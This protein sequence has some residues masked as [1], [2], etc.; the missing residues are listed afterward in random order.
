MTDWRMASG[1]YISTCE[2]T[3]ADA[4]TAAGPTPKNLAAIVRNDIGSITT[5]SGII[6]TVDY[7]GAKEIGRG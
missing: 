1:T 6:Q 7:Q 2:C 3:T 4:F 5:L